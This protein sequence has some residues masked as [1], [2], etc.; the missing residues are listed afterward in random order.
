MGGKNKYFVAID[1]GA[2]SGA[3]LALFDHAKKII[4]YQELIKQEF[5]PSF[6]SLSDNLA[7]KIKALSKRRT[8]ASIGIAT[9]GILAKDGSYIIAANSDYMNGQNLKEVVQE[10]VCVPCGIMND[11]DCGGLAEWIIAQTELLYWVLGGGFGGAWLNQNGEVMYPTID[12]DKKD[13]SLHFTNEPGYAVPLYKNELRKRFTQHNFDFDELEAKLAELGKEIRGPSKDE[14]TLRTELLVSG[15]GLPLIYYSS[16][17]FRA[18]PDLK[19]EKQKLELSLDGIVI[20]GRVIYNLACSHDSIALKTFA[21]FG[22]IFADAAHAILTAAH[23]DGAEDNI[24][25]YL[26]GGV[27]ASLPFYGPTLKRRLT[28]MGHFNYVRPS[29]LVNRGINP[30]LLGA[31]VLAERVYRGS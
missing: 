15:T 23:A 24:P 11:A 17:D 31:A 2:G 8:I 28:E 30:N 27:L 26:A 3:K 29:N 4:D 6:E 14:K 10:R 22:E 9:N 1:L 16:K 20:D 19:R 21:L 13:E 25:I 18:K 7:S 5:E 12:W